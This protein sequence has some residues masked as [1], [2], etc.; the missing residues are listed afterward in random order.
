[1]R[2]GP[3]I[4]LTPQSALLTMRLMWGG[5]VAG[6]ATVAAFV[7]SFMPDEPIL[8]G[9]VASILG[10][11]C[12]GALGVLTPVALFARNQTYKAHWRENA[13]SPSGFVG[14]NVQF[15]ALMDGVAVGSLI[16]I[17][18]TGRL[19]PFAY[20]AAGAVLVLLAN[21]PTGRPMEP[22]DPIIGERSGP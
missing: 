8:D 4:Q 15:F 18:V 19:T 16:C 7:L 21:F 14:G 6:I 11:V 12:M 2:E 1:M 22:T 20:V 17:F 10:Y 9:R 3:D 5:A 13:I